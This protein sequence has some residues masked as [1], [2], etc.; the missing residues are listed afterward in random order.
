MT[1]KMKATVE[2]LLEGV[3]HK[4]VVTVRRE[5]YYS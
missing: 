4:P 5:W 1:K 3:S 2:E